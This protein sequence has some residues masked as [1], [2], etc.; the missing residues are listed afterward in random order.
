MKNTLAERL[1]EVMNGPPKISTKALAAACNVKPPS[2]SGW[3]KGRSKTIEGGNLLAAAKF[4]KV[5]AE[6]L[7][8]GVGPKYPTSNDMSP[9]TQVN[10]NVVS[11]AAAK[12]EHDK[13]IMEAIEILK[14]LKISQREGAIATLRTY[15]Q[16]LG[17]PRDQK[18]QKQA[19]TRS[20]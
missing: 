17:F 4:L 13:W 8:H 16:N 2:V 11:Y 20:K 5:R 18:P 7:A 14:K 3:R 10:Q 12:D 19:N 6:W 15:V 1:V 9:E